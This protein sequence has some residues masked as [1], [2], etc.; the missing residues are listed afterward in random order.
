MASHS[1]P[2]VQ[3]AINPPGHRSEPPV[4]MSKTE[5][6]EPQPKRRRR[7]GKAAPEEPPPDQP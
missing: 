4:W 2:Y 3:D 7:K 5:K 6:L 1:G